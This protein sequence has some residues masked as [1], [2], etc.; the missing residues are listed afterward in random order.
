MT[1]NKISFENVD[2]FKI[3]RAY[4]SIFIDD[5][6]KVNKKDLDNSFHKSLQPIACFVQFLFLMP[7]CGITSDD[8][9]KLVF[10]WMSLRVAITLLYVFYGMIISVLF[11]DGIRHDINPMS[12]GE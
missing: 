1:V 2:N 8:P 7:V 10:K 3:L 6:A 9:K 11:F 5:K 12:V 4:R